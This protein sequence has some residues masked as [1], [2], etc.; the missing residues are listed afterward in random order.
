MITVP[1]ILLNL[2]HEKKLAE[3][4]TEQNAHT[5]RRFESQV[6]GDEGWYV[7]SYDRGQH[8]QQ[9]QVFLHKGTQGQQ[10]DILVL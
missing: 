2:N 10:R 1:S 6:E 8:F 3:S 9:V 5:P 7:A 4:M